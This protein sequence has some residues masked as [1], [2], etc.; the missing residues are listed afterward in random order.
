MGTGKSWMLTVH[1]KKSQS[2]LYGAHM[3]ILIPSPPPSNTY[4]YACVL[5]EGGVRM[6]RFQ[7]GKT[8][9]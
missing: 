4:T 2:C 9:A 3:H 6:H 7:K 8:S 5:G 1:K